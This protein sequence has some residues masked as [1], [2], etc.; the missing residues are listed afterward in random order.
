MIAWLKDHGRALLLLPWIGLILGLLV[1]GAY[2][3]Y[4]AHWHLYLQITALLLLAI[5]FVGE[6]I[7][8]SSAQAAHHCHDPGCGCEAPH[9]APLGLNLVAAHLV[10]LALFL[11]V[12][13]P[14]LGLNPDVDKTAGMEKVPLLSGTSRQEP[15]FTEDGYENTDLL[16]L[17]RDYHE[18]KRLPEKI[19]L[20]GQFYRMSEKDL[21]KNLA[22]L[23]D[24]GIKCILFRFIMTCCAAD[25]RPLSVWIKSEE[26]LDVESR[27]WL[28]LKGK[29]FI[30]K[31]KSDFL[32]L[33]LHKYQKVPKPGNPYL[34]AF[35]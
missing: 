21:A 20:V 31:G 11:V 6:I 16:K 30:L 14:M 12:G 34:L 8:S 24:E 17:H 23:P 9:T 28:E 25:A 15:Q 2:T 3:E 19:A 33:K 7:R 22:G 32:A 26:P 5:A 1:S 35:F 10:P 27:V 18:K 4:V 13:P 29:P